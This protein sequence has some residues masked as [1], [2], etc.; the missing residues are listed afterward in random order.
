MFRKMRRQDAPARRI[1]RLLSLTLGEARGSELWVREGRSGYPVT[2]SMRRIHLEC[3]GK[4][5]LREKRGRRGAEVSG[6]WDIQRVA[7]IIF[8]NFQQIRAE[9]IIVPFSITN[10]STKKQYCKDQKVQA[11]FTKRQLQRRM[12]RIRHNSAR[13]RPRNL[14]PSTID[15]AMVCENVNGICI[16]IFCSPRPTGRVHSS[17]ESNN[18]GRRGVPNESCYFRKEKL[19]IIQYRKLQQSCGVKGWI[20]NKRICL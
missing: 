14:K 2:G 11:W 15:F 8:W 10:C 6:V 3:G 1:D 16:M 9:K 20:A 7:E 12:W 5:V 13:L 18:T 4:R 17:R 19:L